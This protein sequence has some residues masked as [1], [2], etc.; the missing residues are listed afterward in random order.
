[1]EVHIFKTNVRS[2]K[3]VSIV[4][5]RLDHFSVINRWNFDLQDK[6]RILRIE[7]DDLSPKLIENVLQEA[8]YFCQELQ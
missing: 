2:K 7:A 8:G 1:M 3:H 5:H 6:D 4:A